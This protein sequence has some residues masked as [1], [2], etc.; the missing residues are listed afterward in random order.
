MHKRRRGPGAAERKTA[1]AAGRLLVGGV[2]LDALVG[3]NA[4][5]PFPRCRGPPPRPRAPAR[6]WKLPFPSEKGGR[7]ARGSGEVGEFALGGGRGRG[8]RPGITILIALMPFLEGEGL[9]DPSALSTKM[10]N[11][12]VKSNH[13]LKN[14]K[15]IT[16]SGTL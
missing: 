1:A 11:H 16:K 9:G 15:S 14:K 10:F 3:T 8:P 5:T 2:G 4:L 13:I 12:C 6:E 7:P